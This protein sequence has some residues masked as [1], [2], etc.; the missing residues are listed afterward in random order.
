MAG[1]LRHL[2][3]GADLETSEGTILK[4]GGTFV[5]DVLTLK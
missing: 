3:P 4:N 5:K 1:P 2:Q